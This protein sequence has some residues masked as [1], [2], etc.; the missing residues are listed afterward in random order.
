MK[1]TALSVAVPRNCKDLSE[2]EEL[3]GKKTARK[4]STITGISERRVSS[5]IRPLELILSAAEAALEKAGG[6]HD[7]DAVLVVTQTPEYKFPATACL[8]QDHL[9]IPTQSLAFDINLGCSGYA[10]GL[11]TAYSYITSGM[12]RKILLISG[13]MTSSTAS[14]KDSSTYPLFGDAYS[15]TILESSET[16]DVV[17]CDWGTDGSGK[18]N[19]I[20]YVGGSRYRTMDEYQ[21]ADGFA[22]HQEALYPDYCYMNGAQVFEFCVKV[23]PQML[24]NLFRKISLPRDAV[25]F[26]FFHQAN[27]FILKHLGNKLGIAEDKVPMTLYKYGNTSSASIPLTISQTFGSD[28]SSDKVLSALLGFGVGYSWAGLLMYIQPEAVL[29]ILEV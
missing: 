14:P 19:L 8:V 18:E 24:D 12:F 15:A 16:D 10:Y 23:V 27:S 17:A 4:I 3:F 20:T 13:E 9:N 28:P 5:D 22:L 29:P 2:I 7:V 6:P 21:E 26:Y 25:D 11:I 1:I